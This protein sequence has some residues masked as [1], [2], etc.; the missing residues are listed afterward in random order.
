M[1]TAGSDW[2]F[3]LQIFMIRDQVDDTSQL[4]SQLAIVYIL[5]VR[6]RVTASRREQSWPYMCVVYLYLI[7]MLVMDQ[8]R[9][10]G[11]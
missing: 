1:N 2:M 10:T 8:A 3:S 11:V 6:A 9:L 4:S 7:C 5:E